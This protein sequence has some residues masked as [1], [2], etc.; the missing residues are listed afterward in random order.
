MDKT[1][2]IEYEDGE[3]PVKVT[4]KRAS[5]GDGL[6]RFQLASEGDE[7]YQKEKDELK[8][9]PLLVTYPD[10]RAATVAAEGIP[11]PFSFDQF[12]EF[13][14]ALINLWAEAVY[15]LNPQWK[16]SVPEQSDPKKEPASAKR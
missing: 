10:F 7:Q 9:F 12:L 15:G 3:Q 5:F 4:V 16:L 2:T 6:M 13:D 11:Y 8:R 1:K 14:E